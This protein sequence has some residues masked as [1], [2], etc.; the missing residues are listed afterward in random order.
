MLLLL[1][2]L[3]RIVVAVPLQRSLTSRVTSVIPFFPFTDCEAMVVA[4]DVL[5][6]M[7]STMKAPKSEKD[8]R[9]YGSITVEL[10]DQPQV[11]QVSWSL[12][13]AYVE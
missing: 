5:L 3:C 6:D 8:G 13:L 4:H 9:M 10:Q 12:K 7:Q 2:M 1:V 11:G